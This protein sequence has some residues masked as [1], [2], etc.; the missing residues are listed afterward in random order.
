MS[1][2]WVEIENK[3]GNIVKF[4][5]ENQQ[6]QGI[7]NGYKV[8]NSWKQHNITDENTGNEY[9]FIGSTVLDKKLE[10][11]QNGEKIRI[12]YKGVKKGSKN[13]YKDFAVFKFVQLHEVV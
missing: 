4:E 2:E 10:S 9:Q 5:V 6:V 11:I 3:D 12:V 8:V 1:E 7:Y 13:L